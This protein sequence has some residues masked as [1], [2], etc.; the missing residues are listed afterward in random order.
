MMDA[1][2]PAPATSAFAPLR[3]RVF[4]ALGAATALNDP[5][6]HAVTPDLLPKEDLPAGVALSAVGINIGRTIGPALGG[7]FVA[8]LGP[9]AVFALDALA[10]VGVAIVVFASRWETQ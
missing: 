9:G 5:A 7:L 6:W 10:F 3:Q 1:P 4:R 2:Q 8:T